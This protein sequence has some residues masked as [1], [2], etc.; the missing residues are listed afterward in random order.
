MRRTLLIFF[1]FPLILFGKEPPD[2]KVRMN[3][4][5]I[6]VYGHKIAKL[7]LIPSVKILHRIENKS[8]YYKWNQARTQA[9]IDKNPEGG[10]LVLKLKNY[11][12][13]LTPTQPYRVRVYEDSML[14]FEDT[15][16]GGFRP[17]IPSKY[18]WEY[19]RQNPKIILPLCDLTPHTLKI[20]YIENIADQT[21]QRFE[22]VC[23]KRVKWQRLFMRL[24]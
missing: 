16:Q 5:E 19:F 18:H 12:D 23:T 17:N 20:V 13:A 2:E 22:I 14:V 11:N 1:L 15:V 4:K 6:H 3:P 8:I 10:Y 21:V 7:K 24:K 9:E